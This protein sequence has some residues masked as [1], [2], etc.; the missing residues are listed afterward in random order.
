MHKIHFVA[1]KR[2]LATSGVDV[3][4][5]GLGDLLRPEN[6]P[7][8]Q[9]AIAVGARGGSMWQ[10]ISRPLPS[11]EDAE[12]AIAEGFE[13][14][15]SDVGVRWARS[16]LASGLARIVP[17]DLSSPTTIRVSGKRRQIKDLEA[18]Y[19]HAEATFGRLRVTNPPGEADPP[20]FRTAPLSNDEAKAYRNWFEETFGIK[21]SAIKCELAVLTNAR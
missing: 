10:L 8:G 21:S 5:V 3:T 15:S 16:L 14:V 20:E 7:A 12:A 19:A 9:W 4:V 6:I 1:D 17:G 18:A 13:P 11:R 2:Q